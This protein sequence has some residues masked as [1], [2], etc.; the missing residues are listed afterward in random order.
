LARELDV[1]SDSGSEGTDESEGSDLGVAP[2]ALFDTE[3][4]DDK[5]LGFT[6]RA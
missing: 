5:F 1:E 4:D 3:S 6:E 2:L